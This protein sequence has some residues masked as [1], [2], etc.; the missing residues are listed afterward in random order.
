MP[1]EIN[2]VVTDHL[3]T[4]L[5]C[6]T[7]TAVKNLEEE[8]ITKGVHLVGDV[9]YDALLYNATLAEAR[10]RVLVGLKVKAKEYWLAT[11]H[12]AENTDDAGRLLAILEAFR[13]L[14]KTYPVIWPVHPRTW[15]ML[16]QYG[17]PRD[18]DH[19]LR[20]IEP[21]PYLDMLALERNARAILTDSG[22]VQ[23]EA[24]WLGVPCV[25]LR[26][27][28]EWVETTDLG[29]NVV[30]GTNPEAICR[31]AHRPLPAEPVAQ[32]F[33]DGRAAESITAVLIGRSIDQ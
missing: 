6:P 32:P 18:S 11:V 10:S 30:V 33:G 29:W 26:E 24:Y 14:G 17:P 31:G 22:G 23:K 28:T 7:Q 19:A 9:M 25:T 3:S 12:R 8:G 1:E 2:R 16:Q 4:L 15:K 27:E 21:V 5:F 13:E 20:L